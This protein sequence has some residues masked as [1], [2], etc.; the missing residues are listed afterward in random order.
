MKFSTNDVTVMRRLYNNGVS[1]K[2]I[3]YS[4]GCDPSTVGYHVNNSTKK[5]KIGRY[6]KNKIINLSDM[7]AY[8]FV[9]NRYYF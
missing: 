9:A 4:F 1:M 3:A 5:R 6:I 7:D 2:T 8:K